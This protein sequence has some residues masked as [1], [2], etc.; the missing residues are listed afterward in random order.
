MVPAS[1]AFAAEAAAPAGQDSTV[2]GT[3]TV[4]GKPKDYRK[5]P[6][7]RMVILGESTVEG[8]P[9]L[10]ETSHRYADILANLIG[11]CQG[12]P[13]EYH[14]KGIGANAISTRS[15]GYEQSRK[16]SAMERYNDDVIAIKPDLFILAYGLN[17]MRAGMPLDDFREDM[18]IIIRDVKETCN[19]VIILTTVYYMTGWKSYPPYDRGSVE[20]TLKYNDCIRSL[21]AEFDCIVA[22]LWSAEGG[23]DWLID[24]DGVHANRV[25]NLVIAHK[26]F[27]ALAQHASCLTN[28]NFD[29]L[30]DS[31][32]R[33]NTTESR[34]SV[35]DPFKKTW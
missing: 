4:S 31:K 25:G 6:F 19:P 7:E 22:D 1:G 9:W 30:A 20:L 35:G 2:E 10:E 18:A 26:I 15:P 28:R 23:A 5:I 29:A 13:I 24:P 12:A 11:L 3:S 17:D 32:W 8:G 16:P 27:E 34:A 21:A 14:N 33:K